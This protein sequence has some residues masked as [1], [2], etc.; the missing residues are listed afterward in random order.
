MNKPN[1]IS[2][3]GVGLLGGSLALALKRKRGVRVVGWNHRASSRRKASRVVKV[4]RSFDQAVQG[5][6]II[7]LSS[8]S[9]SI[10][11][12]LRQILP[13]LD[14]QTLVMD[15]SSVKGNVV[16]EALRIPGIEKHFVP[17]HPMAG[18]EKSGP[19]HADPALYEGRTVFLT[20]LPKTS[21]KLLKRAAQFWKS[22]GALPLV[23]DP[24]GHDRQVAL[25]SHLPHL[26]AATLVSLYGRQ[27]KKTP[28]LGR[29]VGSGFRD[30]T[31]IAS[32]NPQMWSDIVEMNSRE[33]RPLLSTFRE[34]LAILERN[35]GKGRPSFW[36]SFFNNARSVRERL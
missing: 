16:A 19:S 24:L 35:L 32:G 15:V 36:R 11:A 21:P 30:F 22:V 13:F 27:Q 34:N 23:M 33:L 17:C 8:H 31:R 12:A 4:A 2:I 5:A 18:K 29:A 6:D 20:P 26:L 28:L 1:K 14:K 3:I 9:A 25:T 10:A 7:L